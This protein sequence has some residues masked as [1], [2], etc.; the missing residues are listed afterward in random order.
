[1]SLAFWIC[2]IRNG[3]TLTAAAIPVSSISMCDAN[4]RAFNYDGGEIR[5]DVI[6]FGL[7]EMLELGKLCPEGMSVVIYRIAARQ[8]SRFGPLES[9]DNV[10]ERLTKQMA[11]LRAAI[12]MLSQDD[13]EKAWS[14]SVPVT[15]PELRPLAEIPGDAYTMDELRADLALHDPHRT[16][17]RSLGPTL[18]DAVADPS[19]DESEQVTIARARARVAAL[20][21][22]G[23][24]GHITDEARASC[25]N[26]IQ[27]LLRIITSRSPA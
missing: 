4:F 25:A 18:T 11:M 27:A 23:G 6:S 19:A 13:R 8:P 9:P 20:L 16:P 17:G 22:P 10:I 15:P 7:R 3:A 1:M 21:L 26:D 14:P 12:G 5:D 24:A 2:L